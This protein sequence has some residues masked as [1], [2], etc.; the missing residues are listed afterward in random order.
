MRCLEPRTDCLPASAYAQVTEETGFLQELNGTLEEN[1]GQLER[2][3]LVRTR[4]CLPPWCVWRVCELCVARPLGP[5]ASLPAAHPAAHTLDCAPLQSWHGR[6][7][8]GS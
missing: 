5:S 3:I 6:R 4:G 2:Q 7:R 8:R 1:Q